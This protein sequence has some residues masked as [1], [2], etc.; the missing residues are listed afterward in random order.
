MAMANVVYQE[1]MVKGCRR[2]NLLKNAATSGYT[3]DGKKYICPECKKRFFKGATPRGRN[4]KELFNRAVYGVLL[5]TK[6]GEHPFAA[7]HCG[8]RKVPVTNPANAAQAGS[9]QGTNAL[10]C[11]AV[12]KKGDQCRYMAKE[13]GLCGVHSNWHLYHDSS[14]SANTPDPQVGHRINQF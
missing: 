4:S 14:E 9:V 7:C 2:H 5:F 13:N 8:Y 1:K 10:R 3:S 12:T 11:K 6:K